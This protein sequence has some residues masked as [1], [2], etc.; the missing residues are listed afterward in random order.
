[1]G[2]R[3]RA[4]FFSSLRQTYSRSARPFAVATGSEAYSSFTPEPL[5][6]LTTRDA[7]NAFNRVNLSS[8]GLVLNTATFGQ[9]TSPLTP[10]VCQAGLKLQF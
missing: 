8:P 4:I 6:S 1:M 7:Y 3:V 5:D 9:S 10:R 2:T